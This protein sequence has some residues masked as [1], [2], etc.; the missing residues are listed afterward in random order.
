MERFVNFCD[1]LSLAGGA[2]SGILMLVGI[3]LVLAEV[4]V[5]TLFSKTLY[6][7]E[8]YS[9]YLMAALTFL[10]L[11]YTLREK[12]HIRMVFLHTVLKGRGRVLLDLYAFI[13]G[14]IFCAVLTSTTAL[15]VWD[16]F[17][18]NS[19]SMQISETYLAIPQAFMPL[20][21]L[22]LTL[23]FAAEACRSILLL[24]SGRY[25]EAEAESSTLGR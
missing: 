23:Q 2:L 15:F 25:E 6:I 21:S 22:V 9:G 20:G 10:A 18:T 5:R 17:L 8:E 3:A 7:T 24:R 1:R 19:K 4:V 11:A 14:F 16:A 12:G 13:A